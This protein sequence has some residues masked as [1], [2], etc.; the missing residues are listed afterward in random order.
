MG[1]DRDVMRQYQVYCNNWPVGCRPWCNE[2]IPGLFYKSD[3]GS[4]NMLKT[5]KCSNGSLFICKRTVYRHFHAE[6]HFQLGRLVCDLHISVPKWHRSVHISTK[7]LYS[8]GHFHTAWFFSHINI[9]LCNSRLFS[10]LPTVTV[11]H[12]IAHEFSNIMHF[13]EGRT[14]VKRRFMSHVSGAC[15]LLAASHTY[16]QDT[17]PE[18]YNSSEK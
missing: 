14:F 18:W 7:K 17:S 13:M 10:W 16:R 1:A 15:Y 6:P 8:R 4:Q 9:H 2:T 11:H 12:W 5:I 3:D